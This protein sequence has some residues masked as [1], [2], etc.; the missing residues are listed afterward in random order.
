MSLTKAA[1]LGLAIPA[2]LVLPAAADDRPMRDP[3]A[4]FERLDADGDGAVTLAEIEDA[5]TARFAGADAD[6]D[7][8]LD[9]DELLAMMRQGAER[10]VDRMIAR[11]DADGDW[12]LSAAEFAEGGSGG[13]GPGR[14][15]ARLDADGDGAV[16]AAE[17]EAGLEAWRGARG[18]G[19]DR[20]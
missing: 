8:R 10:G 6:G 14:L 20:G 17:F 15:L 1:L 3:A 13:R 4:M 16:S 12:A 18:H 5:R 11:R 9:R 19:P 7:G 2:L